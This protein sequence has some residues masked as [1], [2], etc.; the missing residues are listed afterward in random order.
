MDRSSIAF[1]EPPAT[2]TIPHPTHSALGKVHRQNY[3]L[4]TE[5][6]ELA[7]C[8][9]RPPAAA[10]GGVPSPLNRDDDHGLFNH[11]ALGVGGNRCPHSLERR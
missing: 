4:W 11:S 2:P 8:V 10:L 1:L 3:H 7:L 5:Q 9:R 6:Q